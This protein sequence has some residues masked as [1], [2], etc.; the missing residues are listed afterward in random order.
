MEIV[1]DLER[2]EASRRVDRRERVADVED[3]DILRGNPFF[4]CPCADL[5]YNERPTSLIIMQPLESSLFDPGPPVREAWFGP[6]RATFH[7]LVLGTCDAFLGMAERSPSATQRAELIDQE[8]TDEATWNV[9]EREQIAR[10]TEARKLF[11]AEEWILSRRILKLGSEIFA[12]T[13]KQCDGPVF[14]SISH[15]KS[16][17]VVAVSDRL[18]GIDHEVIEHRSAS[19]AARM[20]PSNA[21]E[22]LRAYLVMWR[23]ISIDSAE[24][25]IWGI[26]EASLKASGA[27]GVG[28]VPAVE[29]SLDEGGITTMIPDRRGAYACFLNVEPR[30]ILIIVMNQS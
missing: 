26:K 6:Y 17:V 2:P 29:V 19:W 10:F 21:A 28:L 12:G 20:D 8:M 30:S 15:S 18:I 16:R 13:H 14:T 5:I 7:E 24:T 11:R 3:L 25:A 27:E 9:E 4:I 23:D 1:R 22:S